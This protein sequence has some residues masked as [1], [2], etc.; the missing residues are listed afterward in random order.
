MSEIIITN[1]NKIAPTYQNKHE[2]YE[3]YKYAVTESVQKYEVASP[4]EGNQTVT[5]FYS[6]PPGKSSYPFHYHTV[7]EE[8][9][10]IISGSGVVET[11]D[12]EH[13]VTAG[14]IMVFPA[15]KAGAHKLT[16]TS[17]T[18]N[19]VYLDVDTN[20]TPEIAYYPHSNKVGIRAVNGMRDNFDLGDT[21]DYY[22]NE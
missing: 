17:E 2:K 20:K 21:V 12:G 18:E 7:N 19:L 3:F 8:V 14:D 4:R 13:S 10:Y 15:G 1:M 16:N 5:A 6:L 9:F 22:D 11:F